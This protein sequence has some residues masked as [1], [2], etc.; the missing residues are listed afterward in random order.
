MRCSSGCP[1]ANHMD[2]PRTIDQ[3][4]CFVF[5]TISLKDSYMDVL[6]Q[7]L[8]CSNYQYNELVSDVESQQP[9]NQIHRTH[10]PSYTKNIAL[11]L[12]LTTAYHTV[13]HQFTCVPLCGAANSGPRHQ[14]L[15]TQGRSTRR[16]CHCIINCQ[17]WHLCSCETFCLKH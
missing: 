2:D 7:S 14:R 11:S 10:L 17:S 4:I 15:L 1:K 16:N 8:T 3:H 12:D 13:W 5:L 6:S 9:S